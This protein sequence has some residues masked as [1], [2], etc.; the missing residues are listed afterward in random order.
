MNFKNTALMHSDLVYTLLIIAQ[1]GKYLPCLWQ[2]FF[3]VFLTNL[4]TMF[5]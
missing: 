5:Y 4:E 2:L 3:G 1:Y